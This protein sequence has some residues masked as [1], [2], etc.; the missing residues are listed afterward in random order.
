MTAKLTFHTTH[1]VVVPQHQVAA[2]RAQA[3]RAAAQLAGHRSTQLASI[4]GGAGA[5]RVPGAWGF[6]GTRGDRRLSAAAQH[7]VYQVEGA[8][9]HEQARAQA[10]EHFVRVWR[11]MAQDPDT[12]EALDQDIAERVQNFLTTVVGP[13]LTQAALSAPDPRTTRAPGAEAGLA[14]V[15][16]VPLRR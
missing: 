12:G 11:T 15:T 3:E 10:A 13:V 14:A 2:A 6:Y 4:R 1:E 7:L 5:V 9:T 16:R 8:G